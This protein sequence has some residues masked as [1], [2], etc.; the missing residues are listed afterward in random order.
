MVC[1][2]RKLLPF[3]LRNA[4]CAQKIHA[5]VGLIKNG[6]QI[7]QATALRLKKELVEKFEE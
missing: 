2:P 3:A 1:R 4:A 6:D 7:D 5:L